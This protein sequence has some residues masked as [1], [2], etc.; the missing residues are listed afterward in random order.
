MLQETLEKYGLK[1][2]R[3]PG[4]GHCFFSCIVHQWYGVLPSSSQFP[5]LIRQL[6]S[7][8]VN[9][10][11]HRMYE[12]SFWNSLSLRA[13]EI[14]IVSKQDRYFLKTEEEILTYLAALLENEFANEECLY[15]VVE[16]KSKPIVVINSTSGE[17]FC[18]GP[19]R[20]DA[21]YQNKNLKITCYAL[22][23]KTKISSSN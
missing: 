4:D 17:E 7:E 8:V 20:I 23:I 19:P 18:L 13:R 10:L 22:K 5:S 6:R 15:A 12:E 3:V 9:Y 2:F 16:L 1:I 14:G 21:K 11:K